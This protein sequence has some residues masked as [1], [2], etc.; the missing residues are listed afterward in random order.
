MGV[1]QKDI[2]KRLNLSQ[3]LVARVLGNSQDVWVSAENRRLIHFT[4]Q[5]LGYQPNSA[6][7]MLRTGKAYAVSFCY[8]S[9]PN[10]AGQYSAVIEACAEEL[11]R[12]DYEMKIKVYSDQD[13]IMAG[14]QHL[15]SSRSTDAVILWGEE[16]EVEEQ[17]ELLS[18]LGVPFLVKG[19]H[20]N[21]HPEWMQVDFDHEGMMAAAVDF[22]HKAGRTRPV[23]FGHD[24]H[25]AYAVNLR[26]GFEE[27]VLAHSGHP[28]DPDRV[29]LL[30]ERIDTPSMIQS[31]VNTW[32]EKSASER[33][34][35]IIMGVGSYIWHHTELAL[36][37]H[38]VVIGDSPDETM[39]VG[40]NYVR[41]F[42]VF[43]RGWVFPSTQTDTL[44]HM[45]MSELLVPVITGE[46][47]EKPVC[48]IL[49]ALS[50][51]PPPLM[52]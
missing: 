30:P 1:T 16:A 23:F 39:V 52:N 29:I 8:V 36:K 37:A 17:G 33:P 43:G 6:A 46:P 28:V 48:R 3:S 27:A 13:G 38:N 41:D 35:A 14:L 11:G 21:K 12:R 45:M 10:T 19:R 32:F 44:A 25:L 49:P 34:D 20:E 9:A 50:Q 7:R 5:E 31:V 24:N 47:V 42:L 26:K 51:M 40:I 15:A 22:C 2:A 4:A 18:S